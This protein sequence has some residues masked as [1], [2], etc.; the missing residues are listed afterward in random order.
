[1]KQEELNKKLN[2]WLQP[3]QQELLEAV[4]FSSF[5]YLGYGGARGGAKSHGVRDVAA[6]IS[7]K[8][9]LTV[10]IFR[11]IREEL[12]NNHVYPFLK[13]YPFLRKYFNKQELVIYH[14]ITGLPAIKFGYAETNEDI[15]KFQGTEYAVIFI[16]EA[17]KC[18]QYQI[19]FLST[20]NRDPQEIFVPKMVLTMNPGGVSHAY[21]KR[22]FIDKVYLPNE[23]PS[24][25]Y[26]I[27]AFVWDN[28]Y[29]VRKQLR[30]EVEELLN[31][32]KNKIEYSKE[33]FTKIMTTMYYSWTDEKRKEYCL[34]HSSYAKRL[35]TLPHDLMMAF[36]LGDWTVFAGMF[37]K[38]LDIKKQII[39]PFKIPDG[40]KLY[41][42]LD[43]GFSSPCSFSISA[44]DYDWNIYRVANYYESGRSAPQHAEAVY[45]FIK[46]LKL[47]NGRMPER[48]VADPSAWQKRDRFA[49]VEDLRTFADHFNEAGIFL[50]KGVNDRV[51]GWW[52]MKDFMTR[53]E[54]DGK[55]KYLIFDGYNKPF[56]D[57][58]L[59]TMSDNKQSEDIE[60]RGNNP[61]VEDHAIDEERYKLMM[62]SESIP[63]K[64]VDPIEQML[65]EE[66]GNDDDNYSVMGI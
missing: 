42:S 37:F 7:F 14:P 4:L 24:D 8:L 49:A 5:I 51:T 55:H 50:E 47:T 44:V 12:L 46:N 34:K 3:K 60:G 63:A 6:T 11:R 36:L 65:E 59:G 58:L 57:Q 28:W 30:L 22:I 35:S 39:K 18:T 54:K 43:P 48:I 2:I 27:Q 20:C 33:E 25:Y 56:V 23:N 53:K 19:E 13:H 66:L 15:E 61:D 64:K 1:M 29:W 62:V 10:L 45:S 40:W 16:D 52:N 31:K 17:T 38:G 21:V 9:N 41:A 32:A 26:F